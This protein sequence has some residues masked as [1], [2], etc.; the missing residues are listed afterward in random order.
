MG[1]FHSQPL[2]SQVY[3]LGS[4]TET[5]QDDNILEEFGD[6]FNSPDPLIVEYMETGKFPDIIEQDRIIVIS[7]D[8][9]D[10]LDDILPPIIIQGTY[11]YFTKA[12]DSLN[13]RKIFLD[14]NVK[15]VI[16]D[17]KLDY[18]NLGNT[19]P[20]TSPASFVSD[21]IINTQKVWEE[22]GFSGNGI[23]IG[24]IDS[25]VDFGVSDLSGTAKLMSSGI[26]ASWDATG[27][28]LGFSNTT[29]QTYTDP[30][31]EFLP[32]SQV[33]ITIWLS[34]QFSIGRSDNMGLR[35]ED[36]EITGIT[37]PSVSGKY[38]VGVMFQPG[39]Q[40]TIPTQYFI[41][42][43]SD[44]STAGEYDTLYVD[45]DTSLAISLSRGGFILESGVT[46]LSL[47]D[48]SLVDEVPYGN[49][50]PI[51]ARDL[52]AD[53]I[54][55]VSMGILANTLDLFSVVNN[56][57]TSD[58]LNVKGIDKQGRGFAVMYDPVGHG[59]LT[60]SANAGQGQ[61]SI[62]LFDDKTTSEIENG[63]S[64]QLYGSAP[65]ASLIATKA[66]TIQE[67]VM[68]WYWTAGL[69]IGIDPFGNAL[70]EVTADSIEHR[71]EL[72]TN[73]W[74][75]GVIGEDNQLRGQDMNSLLLDLFSAPNLIYPGYPGIVY[76][77][78]TGNSG[79]AYGGVARPGAASMAITV[80]MLLGFQTGGQ[81]H[82]EQ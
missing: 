17:Y 37:S 20:S 53:G 1:N 31:G 2:Y 58:G 64:Y 56:N 11:L 23:T 44:S 61:S 32:L 3:E 82:M 65:N 4:E 51:V 45:L 6:K 5:K 79:P 81:L 67:F 68:G 76:V 25:G 24:I 49:F 33:N 12:E 16:P 13:L 26:S 50:N 60:A 21:D 71:V 47:A 74:G 30:R 36:L 72:T 54:N 48:W 66:L 38:K 55:D 63:T 52:D 41:F 22:F 59:T 27:A 15:Q 28:G 39:F 70:W 57:P 8:E 77:V 35:L 29:L 18:Q 10:Y 78:A 42:I 69:E 80:G 7:H 14:P 19:D 46:Y 73:S 9:L 34:D 62:T 43:L 40:E 75:S